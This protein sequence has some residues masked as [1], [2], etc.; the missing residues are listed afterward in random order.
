MPGDPAQC[1]E[2]AASCRRLAQG[3]TVKT[4]RDTFLNLAATWEALA[5]E[6]E[7]AERFIEAM[8]SIGPPS[9]GDRK[10]QA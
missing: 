10:T 2:H 1:R 3:A 4:A 5:T 8:E 7:S 9:S 6:L